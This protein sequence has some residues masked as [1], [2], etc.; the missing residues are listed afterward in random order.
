MV[1]ETKVC[2]VCGKEKEISCF[3]KT[4]LRCR[5]CTKEYLKEYRKN[6]YDALIAKAKQRYST[7]KDEILNRQRKAYRKD[8]RRHMLGTAKRRAAEKGIEFDLTI[9]DIVIPEVCPVLGIPFTIGDGGQCYS[10][11]TLDR[12]DNTKGYVKGN[13]RVI[14]WRANNL[15]RDATID[16]LKKILAYMEK[17][18]ETPATAAL[19]T[20]N[21]NTLNY[22][23]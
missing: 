10:S 17:V 19:L 7:N 22:H 11:P 2:N 1:E 18:S 4:G 14:S 6:N 9:D 3:P 23:I 12:T 5:E 16:E 13:V 15:K 21:K 20:K 8:F